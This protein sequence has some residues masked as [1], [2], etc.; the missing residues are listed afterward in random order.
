MEQN[1]LTMQI[2]ALDFIVY[3]VADL[4]RGIAF[5]RDVLGLPLTKTV[6]GFWA[7]FDLKPSTLALFC[8]SAMGMS[9][10]PIP[11][12]TVA[13]AVP[14]VAAATA[15][16]K[17]KGVEFTMEGIET[18]VCHSAYFV[19]PDGNGLALHQRKDGTAG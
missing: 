11:G 2:R 12:G 10:P 13:L 18:P 16:L 14:D 15:E 1:A 7:E 9:R 5:Y 4:H 19:D 3:E 8:P 6:E 17:A